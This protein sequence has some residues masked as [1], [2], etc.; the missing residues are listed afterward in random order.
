MIKLQNVHLARMKSNLYI[1]LMGLVL[2]LVS[3]SEQ[4][5]A[6]NVGVFIDLSESVRD[7]LRVTDC[8]EPL[9]I[10]PLE[11]TDESLLGT[12]DKLMEHNGRY[13]V[14]DKMRK[15]VLVFD[16][17]GKFLHR[18]GR[19]G[20]GPGE[21][22]D[23]VDF[24]VDGNTGYLYLLAQSSTIYVY[25]CLGVFL[26]RKRLSNSMFWNI[27]HHKNGFVCSSNHL[28]HTSGEDAF[29]LYRYE[30]DFQ[31]RDRSID[32]YEKQIFSPLFISSPFQKWNDGFYYMDTFC[33]VVYA[34]HKE[35]V[36]PFCQFGFSSP[37]PIEYFADTNRF[38]ENQMRFDFVM[39][40][41]FSNKYLWVSYIHNGNHYTKIF[42]MFGSRMVVGGLTKGIMP[43]VYQSGESLLSPISAEEYLESWNHLD[44]MLKDKINIEDNHLILKWKLKE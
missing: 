9:D 36:V 44:K 4:K 5:P 34:L 26:W 10:I 1:A 17:S 21:Y 35:D 15:G 32:V 28:T 7:T 25:D 12:V 41:F 18:A 43:K 23:L 30:G 19:I 3:C 2:A 29:L 40:L 42:D 11:T 31:E 24:T 38:M 8:M 37:M 13:Y 16:S 22:Q 39:E 20:Q 14:L 6:T 27:G 33:N